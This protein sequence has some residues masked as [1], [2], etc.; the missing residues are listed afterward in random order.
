MVVAT[1]RKVALRAPL[2]MVGANIVIVV[3]VVIVIMFI[4]IMIVIA[5]AA[6]AE[7]KRS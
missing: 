3:I 7:G 5:M 1:I 2:T 6:M 4:I